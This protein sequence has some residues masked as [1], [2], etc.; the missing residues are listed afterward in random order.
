MYKRLCFKQCL[1]LNAITTS[2]Y[3]HIH[4]KKGGKKRKQI[5]QIGKHSDSCSRTCLI[6][7]CQQVLFLRKNRLWWQAQPQAVLGELPFKPFFVCR[8]WQEVHLPWIA[9][10][11]PLFLPVLVFFNSKSNLMT[12]CSWVYVSFPYPFMQRSGVNLGNQV[13]NKFPK[14]TLVIIRVLPFR[15]QLPAGQKSINQSNSQH[16]QLYSCLPTFC[17]PGGMELQNSLSVKIVAVDMAHFLV[18]FG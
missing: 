12:M 4:A 1:L 6:C 18:V 11:N 13:T 16:F 10:S 9:R 17:F 7:S 14:N 3:S 2:N 15:K 8:M 5:I